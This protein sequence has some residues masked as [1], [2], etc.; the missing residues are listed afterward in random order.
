MSDFST[1]TVDQLISDFEDCFDWD[2]RFR[3]VIELG[4]MLP[5]LDAS[6][7]TEENRILGCQSDAWMVAE[8]RQ[9]DE[10]KLYFFADSDT[11][12]VK[13]LIAVVVVAYSGKTPTEI[14]AFDIDALFEQLDLKKHLSPVRGNGLLAMV[15]KI[16]AL[17]AEHANV[18]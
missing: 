18:Q 13:G 12:I 9:E 1:I 4:K 16:K 2:D 5:P 14:L 7:K 8:V 3:Y 10:F 6:F 15:K 17:A 11:F